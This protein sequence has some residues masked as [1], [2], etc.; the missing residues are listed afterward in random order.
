MGLSEL[1]VTAWATLSI[2]HYRQDSLIPIY[3]SHL[4]FSSGSSSCH[5]YIVLPHYTCG[6]FQILP[7]PFE[8][9]LAAL[10]CE[11]RLESSSTSLAGDQLN[12]FNIEA[13]TASWNTWHKPCLCHVAT[14]KGNIHTALVR[15][16]EAN[17]TSPSISLFTYGKDIPPTT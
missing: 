9:R 17:H 7:L 16:L 8:S 12:L 2:S 13:I 1:M 11:C 3:L 6:F 5:C 15:I 14:C 10:C 4:N